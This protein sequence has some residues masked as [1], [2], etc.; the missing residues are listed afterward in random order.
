MKADI[1]PSFQLQHNLLSDQIYDMIKALIK[2]GEL[3][4]GEQVVESSL[5]KKMKVSQAPV[6][7]ALKRLAHDGL[8]THIR[9]HGNFVAK[10]SKREADHA[11][12]ARVAVE[13]MA[14]RIACGRITPETRKNLH[15][16]IDA[17]HE[18]VDAHDI[19]QFRELDF[20]FHRT[21]VTDSGNI[22]LPRLWDTIEPSLRSMHVLSDPAFDGDWHVVADTH[23]RLIDVLDGDDPQLAADLF[24]SHAMGQ[25]IHPADPVGPAL[26]Q[27]IHDI[28]TSFDN[29]DDPAR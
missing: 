19:G 21:V 2:S 27:I 16:I 28:A 4:P 23:R 15:A 12:V 11:R 5:A 20:A 9:H 26:D 14:G 13:S 18:A 1:Q 7:E 29:E 6:R 10:F 24:T 22:Y 25:S 17:M 8:V 3:Q